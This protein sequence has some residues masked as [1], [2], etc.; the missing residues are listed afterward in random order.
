MDKNK[1]LRDRIAELEREYGITAMD[2]RKAREHSMETDLNILMYKTELDRIFQEHEQ[3]QRELYDVMEQVWKL[4]NR[5][6]SLYESLAIIDR[7]LTE[8]FLESDNAKYVQ[9]LRKDR[10]GTAAEINK[11]NATLSVLLENAGYDLY[12]EV[13]EV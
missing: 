5:R 6:D 13:E 2:L 1:P 9:A 12:R 10:K 7:K 11:I 4:S 3:A 8:A